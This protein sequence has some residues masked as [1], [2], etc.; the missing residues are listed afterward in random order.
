MHANQE[1]LVKLHAPTLDLIELFDPTNM[2]TEVLASLGL[3]G[4]LAF[5]Y[6]GWTIYQIASKLLRNPLIS[7]EEKR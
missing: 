3:C 4:L 6:F 5:S 7:L 1:E 2:F